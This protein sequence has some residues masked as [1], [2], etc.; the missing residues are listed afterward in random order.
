MVSW[1]LVAILSPP[2][3][4]SPGCHVK[5]ADRGLAG[6]LSLSPRMEK[7]TISFE[8]RVFILF[9]QTVHKEVQS[10]TGNGSS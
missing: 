4:L 9:R 3:K 7:N 2:R 8:G 10:R 6:A 5:D 1:V